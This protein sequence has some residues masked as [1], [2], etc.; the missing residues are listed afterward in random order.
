MPGIVAIIAALIF[1]IVLNFFITRYFVRPIS[2]LAEAV[3]KYKEGEN[4]LQANITS[5][6]EI[7]FLEQAINDLIQRSSKHTEQPL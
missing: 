5:D 3:N 2:E 6:D 1:S 7:K 4:R